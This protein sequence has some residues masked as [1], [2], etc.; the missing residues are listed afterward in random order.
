MGM[1]N[2]ERRS[3]VR[4]PGEVEGGAEG[5]GKEKKKARGRKRR[6]STNLGVHPTRH[7]RAHVLAGL[8]LARLGAHDE[9]ADDFAVLVVRHGDDGGF[10][11]G[12][13]LRQP[14][15]DLDWE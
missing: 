14:V 11:H 8:H 10:V 13:V 1:G 12:G 2:G 15:L 7:P 4:R 9:R 5:G 6:W 3:G